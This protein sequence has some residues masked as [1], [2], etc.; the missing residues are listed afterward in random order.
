MQK[1]YHDWWVFFCA[2][3]RSHST[4]QESLPTPQKLLSEC[5][6]AIAPNSTGI[7]L[8]AFPFILDLDAVCGIYAIDTGIDSWYYVYIG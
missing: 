7:A 2:Y 4:P 3:R 5:K 1:T 6:V 8:L